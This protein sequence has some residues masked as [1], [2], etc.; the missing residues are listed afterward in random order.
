[1][2]DR[3]VDLAYLS[4]MFGE[5]LHWWKWKSNSE[6]DLVEIGQSFHM[7]NFAESPSRNINNGR[8]L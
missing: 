7:G 6:L 1:M 5:I 8:R 4:K 2:S 3:I